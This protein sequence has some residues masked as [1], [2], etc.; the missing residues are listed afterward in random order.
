MVK[1]KKYLAAS[2]VF[3]GVAL[4]LAAVM[5]F[6][7]SC[8]YNVGFVQTT[9]KLL[10][11]SNVS[12]DTAMKTAADLYGQ[13]RITDEQKAEIIKIGKTFAGAHNAAVEALASYEETKAVS[14]QEKMSAQIEIASKAL[15]E[16]LNLIKPY[17]T[18]DELSSFENKLTGRG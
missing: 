2:L 9:Y 15:A 8:A 6:T 5:I 16:L 14:E 3:L 10:S 18:K 11:I 12:Y 1:E 13:K 7:Q 4:A 17:L